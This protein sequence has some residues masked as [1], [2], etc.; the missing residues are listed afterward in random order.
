MLRTAAVDGGHPD[1]PG[2]RR[3]GGGPAAGAVVSVPVPVLL[4]WPLVA[5]VE[6]LHLLRHQHRPAAGSCYL[7]AWSALV[8]ANWAAHL[9]ELP[10]TAA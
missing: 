5:C 2:G 3:A 8:V 10:G 1:R 9:P 7:R 6:L 4:G